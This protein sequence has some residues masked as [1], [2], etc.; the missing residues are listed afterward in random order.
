MPRGMLNPILADMPT[1]SL[2]PMRATIKSVINKSKWRFDMTTRTWKGRAKFVKQY[3]WRPKRL[4][5]RTY[6]MSNVYRFIT[7]GARRFAVMSPDFSPKTRPRVIGS[8][9][10]A[11]GMV[12]INDSPV[13]YIK[14][15]EFEEEIVRVMEPKFKKEAQTAMRKIAQQ[16]GHKMR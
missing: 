14:P 12:R 1:F 10:G 5:G 2:E 9:P 13:G 15:R 16:S 8:F 6:T 11:G 3:E 7:R 4:I